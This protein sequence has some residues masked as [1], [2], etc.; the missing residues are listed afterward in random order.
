MSAKY[1][2]SSGIRLGSGLNGQNAP[3]EVQQWAFWKNYGHF[4]EKYGKL[5]K[6]QLG[7]KLLVFPS[8]CLNRIH[9]Q[10]EWELP[11]DICLNIKHFFMQ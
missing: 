3:Y 4:H 1:E 7:A 5:I 11:G 8:N 6:I 10:S 2:Y 9:F